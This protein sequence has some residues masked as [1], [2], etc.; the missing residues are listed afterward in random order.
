MR[1]LRALA[2]AALLAAALSLP[3]LA[4][5]V[6][7][8]VIAR[9]LSDE[10]W[11]LSPGAELERQAFLG[12][13]GE[14]REVW[15]LTVDMGS[16]TLELAT[17]GNDRD[18][19]GGWGFG[20]ALTDMAA[21]SAARGRVPVAAVN[22]DF[23]KT[24]SDGG[25]AYPHYAALGVMV[26]DGRWISDGQRAEGA[27]YFGVTADGRAVMGSAEPDGDWDAVKGG[28]FTALGGELWLIRHGVNNAANATWRTD[29]DTLADRYGSAGRATDEAGNVREAGLTS[30]P[31]SCIGIRA[32]GAVVILTASIGYGTAGLDVVQLTKLMW[33]R[34]CV[35]LMNLDGGPSTQ[36]AADTGAGLTELGSGGF[37]AR[38]ADGLLV[39]PGGVPELPAAGPVG[40]V[41]LLPPFA[42]LAAAAAAAYL[43]RRRRKNSP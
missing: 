29:S 16:N 20:A 4:R 40:S 14:E 8:P 25:A 23:Y 41:W 3:A 30:Y 34:G 38:I 17:P 28:L 2:A 6:D 42:L 5:G 26:K 33:D 18:N 22:G 36:M 27:M 24:A 19:D 21:A 11:T 37:S 13:D 7:D 32:D 10:A 12:T 39:V 43:R 1:P 9:V 15:F 35:E 31:R